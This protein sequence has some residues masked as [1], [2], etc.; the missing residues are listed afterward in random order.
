MTAALMLLIDVGFVA[1]GLMMARDPEESGFIAYLIAGLFALGIPIFVWRIIRP[2]TMTL[3]ADGI[4]WQGMFKTDH[5]PWTEVQ[6]FR[7]YKPTSR[8]IAKHVGFDFTDNQRTGAL[9]RSAKELTGVG[10]S[11]GTGWE[12]G[13]ADLADLLNRAH[14]T[15]LR[16]RR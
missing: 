8:T 14:A 16:T 12:L 10:G 1:I 13:A 2:D 7:A 6:D 11:L 15:W 3:T 4:T 5:W 9:G